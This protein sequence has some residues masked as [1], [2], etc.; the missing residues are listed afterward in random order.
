MDLDPIFKLSLVLY[1]I[2]LVD[3]N[4]LVWLPDYPP[5]DDMKD[6]KVS[7]LHAKQNT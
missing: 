6:L 5:H 1:W 4:Q 7:L 3:E 2:G